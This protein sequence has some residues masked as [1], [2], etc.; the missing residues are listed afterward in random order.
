VNII[1]KLN[2][3]GRFQRHTPLTRTHFSSHTRI[4]SCLS[5][6][7]AFSTPNAIASDLT[8]M[9]LEELMKVKVTTVSRKE[10]NVSDA[11]AAVHVITGDEIRRSG[12][13]TIPEALRLTPGLQVARVDAHQWAVSARGFNDIFA[14]KLLVLMD[15]RSVYTPL[16]SGVYWDTQDVLLED[17]DR[18]EVVRGPGAT[19]WGANAVNGVINI[20]TLT[21]RDTHGLLATA[22][23]GNELEAFSHVRYGGK[24]GDD[25]HYRVFGKFLKHGPLSTP[26]G[27]EANDEWSTQRGGF[28]IDWDVTQDDVITLQS[29]IYD[30]DFDQ[31]F[32]RLSPISPYT[33]YNQK[34]QSSNSGGHM[35]G[36]WTHT[37]SETSDLS[38][39]FYY[40]RTVRNSALL[41][42]NRDTF[43]GD[44]QHRFGLTSW[45]SIVWGAG[46]RNSSDDI[47][48]SFDVALSP[49]SRTSELLSA[50]VQDEITLVPDRL[51][52]ILGSKFE[53]N[54]YTGFEVQPSGRL[55]WRPHDK[56][57]V[58]GSISRAVRTP[59]RAEED[60]R[61]NQQPVYAPGQLA[62]AFPPF[63]PGSPAAVTSLYGNRELDSEKLIAY[64]LG[65]RVQAA[66]RL[67]FDLALFYN[68][69]DDIRAV[70]PAEPALRFVP[71]LHPGAPPANVA[72]IASNGLQAT[73]YGGELLGTFLL[74]DWWRVQASYSYLQINV[75][76]NNA[77]V[78]G[79]Q[80]YF[81]EAGSP[82]HQA[83][84][85][86][87]MDLGRNVELDLILRYADQ[88]DALQVDSYVTGDVRIGWKPVESVELS[89]VARNL[90]NRRR[91]EFRPTVIGT[92]Q[93]EIEP[94]V[95]GK[96]SWQF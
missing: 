46:Y 35:L 54:D 14:N 32:V 24:V 47:R 48:S 72:L 4:L 5:L 93:S 43:E 7:L 1:K 66:S 9:S 31:T 57:T 3:A 2:T 91:T 51:T 15:G 39:Q 16:F 88:L 34:A 95:Y 61:L 38:F 11:A 12:A 79:N 84:L 25:F 74:Q 65:Y 52:L 73:S 59:S 62:P 94:S 56:H 70:V 13:A 76:S 77:L 81:L 41:V 58:W 22:G 28:R 96:I 67:S 36:R 63:F 17:I 83:Y 8:E 60:L 40:D 30:G 78:L 86:S 45:Q 55:L 68:D 29:E 92:E 27:M 49:S 69:Y 80:E 26:D 23:G 37:F 53:N 75:R 82:R 90:F 10:Q 42:E 6:L 33:P 44:F 21:A 64:E 50:F 20:K 87:V 18:I 89:L 71:G 85:R 19:L